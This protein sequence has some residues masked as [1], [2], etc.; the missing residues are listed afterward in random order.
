M[1]WDICTS[2]VP[3]TKQPKL[4]PDIFSKS[5]AFVP[6]RGETSIR[7]KI[8]S[9]QPFNLKGI[10]ATFACICLRPHGLVQKG[11]IY[12]KYPVQALVS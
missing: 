4:A 3:L 2:T 12:W 5:V 10:L 7:R 8:F 6:S 1:F 9:I 11:Q